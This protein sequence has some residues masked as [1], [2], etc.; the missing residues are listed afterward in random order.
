MLALVDGLHAALDRVT[1]TPAWSMS[2]AEQQQ[3]LVAL[4]AAEARVSELKL[5]VLVSADRN[6]AGS[7][8]GAT[9]TVAWLAHQTLSTR[10]DVSRDLTLAAALD[11]GFQV[12]RRALA[13]GVIDVARA[14]EVVRAVQR[15][16][17]EHDDLPVG[18][19][20]A[21]E[22][23]MLELAQDFDAVLLRRL[24]RRLFEVVCP[25]AADDEEGGQLDEE[26]RRARRTA[27]LS[28]RDLGD[29]TVEGRF[30]LPV[31]H[32]AVLKK[33]LESL[34]AP[35]RI[36]EGR[37]DVDTG[38]RL[39]YPTLLGQ[40]FMEL[41]EHHLDLRS[42]PGHAG[43]PFTVVVTVGLEALRRGLGAAALETGERLSTGEARRLAC[44]AGIIPMVLGSDSVPLDLGRE[45]RLFSKHQRIALNH[46]YD[47]CA[48]VGCDRPPSW[49]EIHHIDPWSGGG[50]TDLANALPLC[51]RHHHLADDPAR[52]VASRMPDGSVQFHRR[53]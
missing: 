15:L 20:P 29:G 32:A 21:A 36:G 30:R 8:Q 3:A 35:R 44:G 14:R 19:H 50:G 4:T 41:L 27:H 2:T 39:P 42:L 24:G 46:R 17:D 37:L 52:W 25:E 13:A 9:S 33:A 43:S 38:K 40:G 26:E 45:Q 1:E 34:T 16:T 11:D 12:T 51:P 53:T 28:M 49:L 22:E 48:T 7:D 47:G 6:Q 18:T 31:L 5:R 10:S 23:R